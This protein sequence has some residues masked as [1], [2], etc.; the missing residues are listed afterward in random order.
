MR[1]DGA[2]TRVGFNDE[3]PGQ[4]RTLPKS[5]LSLALFHGHPLCRLVAGEQIIAVVD[6]GC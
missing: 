4:A 2:V 3:D 6:S 5:S 1:D